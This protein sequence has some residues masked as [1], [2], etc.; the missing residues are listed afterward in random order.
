MT[1]LLILFSTGVLNQL[2]VGGICQDRVIPFT[3]RELYLYY[4]LS[5]EKKRILKE[6]VIKLGEREGGGL[7][8]LLL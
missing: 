7:M 4:I 5:K 3:H 2:P 8:D 1:A 6:S